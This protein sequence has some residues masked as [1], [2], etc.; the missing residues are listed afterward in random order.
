VFNQAALWKYLFK[1]YGRT[2]VEEVKSFAK[3]SMYC[4]K[5]VTKGD[6]YDYRLSGD[7][8]AWVEDKLDNVEYNILKDM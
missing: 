8:E 2:Q 7:R 5:Y 6:A 4:A 3:V 1:Q